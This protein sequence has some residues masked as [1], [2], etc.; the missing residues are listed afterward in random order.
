MNRVWNWVLSQLERVPSG[1]GI[2]LLVI[3]AALFWLGA[4][5]LLGL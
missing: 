2:P 5:K 3:I 1:L 4:L